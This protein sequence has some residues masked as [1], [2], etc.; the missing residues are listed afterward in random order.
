MRLS[1]YAVMTAGLLLLGAF[2]ATAPGCSAAANRDAR[3]AAD[4]AV[5]A[6]RLLPPLDAAE[7]A[8]CANAQSA[9]DVIRRLFAHRKALGLIKDPAA[10]PAAPP[11]S[12]SHP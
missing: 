10:A 3:N 6:C 5:E 1:Y 4:A 12:S 9:D 7:Q 2:I 8:I 11:A